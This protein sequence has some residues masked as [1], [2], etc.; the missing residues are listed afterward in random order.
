MKVTRL[1]TYIPKDGW[2]A[3]LLKYSDSNKDYNIRLTVNNKLL[4]LEIQT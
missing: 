2:K 4:T 3:Q 1:N